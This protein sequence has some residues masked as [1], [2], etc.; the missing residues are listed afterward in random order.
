[1]VRLLDNYVSARLAK[2][3]TV[4]CSTTNIQS[5]QPDLARRYSLLDP[6]PITLFKRASLEKGI[7]SQERL[8]PDIPD[9]RAKTKKSDCQSSTSRSRSG[10]TSD[11][12]YAKMENL[13]RGKSSDGHNQSSFSG[14]K[15]DPVK[16]RFFHNPPQIITSSSNSPNK[17]TTTLAKSKKSTKSKQCAEPPVVKA[18][19]HLMCGTNFSSVG[20]ARRLS[21]PSLSSM[22]LDFGMHASLFRINF[23]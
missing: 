21:I 2:D 12:S 16:D 14:F 5:S 4:F 17:T 20:I 19:D 8:T 22:W 3:A 18:S 6:K 13:V 10:S 7:Q 11:L 15:R 1:M 23:L 9:R